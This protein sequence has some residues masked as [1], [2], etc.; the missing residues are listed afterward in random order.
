MRKVVDAKVADGQLDD[1]DLTLADI[2]KI[3]PGVL[4]DA[5]GELSPPGRVSRA[6]PK[7]GSEHARTHHEPSRS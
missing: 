2:E 5:V 3:D 6:E 4:E 1:A 7:G